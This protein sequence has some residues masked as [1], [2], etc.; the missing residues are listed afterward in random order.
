[1][2][3]TSQTLAVLSIAAAILNEQVVS[4]IT[5]GVLILLEIALTVIRAQ[6]F[7]A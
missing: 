2:N 5:A 3:P 7:E 4:M 6:E 1:M